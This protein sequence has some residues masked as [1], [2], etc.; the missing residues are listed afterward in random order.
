MKYI[1]RQDFLNEF[2]KSLPQLE[3]IEKVAKFKAQVIMVPEGMQEMS[4]AYQELKDPTNKMKWKLFAGFMFIF[5]KKN[6]ALVFKLRWDN[7]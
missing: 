6:D 4:K 3:A 7:C 1:T 5:K 2:P